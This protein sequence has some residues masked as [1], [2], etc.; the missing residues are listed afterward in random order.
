MHMPNTGILER[1][2]LREKT[3]R[4]VR[5][6]FLI[7]RLAC[8]GTESQ[9]LGLIQRLDRARVEPVLCLLNGNDRVSKSLEPPDCPV[10]RLGVESLLR[11][12][13][14]RTA[15]HFARW[16]RTNRIDILQVHFP[17]STYFGV[18]AAKL[19][20]LPVIRTRRNLGYWLTA[21]HRVLGRLANRFTAC[22]IAN[23]EAAR[24]ACIDQENAS[25]ESV[26]V[27]PNGIDLDKFLAIPDLSTTWGTRPP[28]I[29]AVANLRAVKGLATLVEAA[30][31]VCERI[32]GATFAVAGEGDDRR[33]LERMIGDRGLTARFHL[34]GVLHD[35]PKFLADIDVA[36]SCSQSEGLSNSMLEYMAAGR[37]IVAT[38][39]GGNMELICNRQNGLLV[40]Y[41][42]LKDTAAAIIQLAQNYEL[43]MQCSNRARQVAKH[44]DWPS[45]VQQYEHFYSTLHYPQS[46]VSM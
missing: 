22:T 38:N 2:D 26:I 14:A 19:A 1:Q 32:P 13:T 18:L 9:L 43:A 21:R 12:S 6:C 30:A 34:R 23:C 7:D 31:V 15:V 45:T 36:V 42:D 5:V 24:Q 33:M 29:G 17:D 37:A 28:R 20:A 8:G 3:V 10:R 25:P 27:L 11:P 16:L 41:N 35:I 40:A 39:V 44:F 46:T 4:P